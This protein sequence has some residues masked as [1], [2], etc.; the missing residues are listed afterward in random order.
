MFR[1]LLFTIACTIMVF[2]RSA[3]G[4]DASALFAEGERAFA[5]GQYGEA[6]RLFTAARE[7]GSAGP[8]SYYN[9]G[10]CQYR[11]GDYAAAEETF[12]ALAAEFP[13]MRELAE[14]NRGLALRADGNDRDARIAFARAR[15]STDEKIAALANA[16]LAEIGAARIANEP[17]WSGYFASGFGYDDNVA[18]IDEGVLP[19]SEASSPLVEVLGVLSRDFGSRPLRFDAS[20]YAVSYPEVRDFDQTA[21]RVSL[22]ADKRLG[23]WRLVAGPTLGRSTFD[24]DGFEELVGADLRI[25]R[26]LGSGFA[27]EARAIYDDVDAGASRF[28]YLEGARRLLRLSFEHAGAAR[29]RAAYDAEDSDRADPGVT[30]S[31]DRWSVVYQ[32]PLSD[33]WS[34]DAALAHRTSQYDEASVPREERLLELSLALRRELGHAWT[35]GVEYQAFD[36][37]STA[38]EFAYDGQRVVLGLSRSFYGN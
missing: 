38:A 3:A 1:A 33:A 20:G 22:V 35:L 21:M 24:G 27:F 18:L 2:P 9:I 4:A 5:S 15:S 23:P 26:G 36:N 16:Q 17:R 31:R 37:D 14:Y 13:A 11:L 28:A 25:R 8:S 19:S 7:A 32:R 10:V 34:V 30:A 29:I 6:L 12:A